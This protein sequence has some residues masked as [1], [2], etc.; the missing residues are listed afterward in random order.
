MSTRLATGG[1]LIDRSKAVEFSWDGKRLSGY[2]GDTLASALLANGETLVGRSFK[3]HRPRGIIACGPEEPN[4]LVGLNEGAR[5]EPN[6][7]ATTTELYDGLTA[8]SQNAWPSLAFDVGGVNRIMSR[9][10][11]AG[12]YYKTFMFPRFAWKHVF[13]PVI[14]KAAGLGAAP[15]KKD[16]DTYEYFYA[17]VD[18]LVVGGG[19]TGLASALE[20][21]RAG[22]KVLLLEQTNTFG[23]RGLVDD[24][25]ING[26]PAEDWV[27]SAIAELKKLPNVTIKPRTMGAG[28]YDHGWATGYER[29]T[30]HAP[31]MNG[32]RHRLWRI[33]A[34]RILAANGAI[35][36]PI[37]FA[38][39]DVPGV[40]WR[41][42]F[43]IICQTMA[44]PVAIRWY[45][46]QTTMMVIAQRLH[47]LR[48]V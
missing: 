11:P 5:F 18:V 32:P 15:T 46:P 37:S 20:A 31:E 42:L 4:A 48:Q 38:G 14:R 1:C 44:H 26:N 41:H 21:G 2:D 22:A 17:T 36:R 13:E 19:L 40:C 23:G 30:D 6:Q 45:W 9:V 28:V 27:K 33:R 7:R 39:N 29:L 16:A 12:F 47:R 34:K 24:I 43:V 3:Y 25:T 35:E 8:K 10:F